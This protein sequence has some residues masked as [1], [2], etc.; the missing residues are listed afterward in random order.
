LSIFAATRPERLG[1]V[2]MDAD[3]HIRAA[4]TRSVYGGVPS[5]SLI[6]ILNS[7]LLTAVLERS[8]SDPRPWIWF[9]LIVGL[10]AVRLLIWRAFRRRP[11]DAPVGAWETAAVACSFLSGLLSGLGAAM[12]FPPDETGQWLWIF[13][14]GGMC[15]GAA[16]LDA[17]HSPTALAFLFPAGVPLALR[18]AAPGPVQ[19]PVAAAMIL[20]F[21]AA[22]SFTSLRFS[23]HF[24]DTQRLQ[25]DLERRTR[26]LDEANRRLRA[27]IEQHRATEDSLRQAQ[28]ME[29]LGLLTGGI[30]H[31][32]NNLLTVITGNLDLMRR[33]AADDEAISRLANA[34]LQAA[35]RGAQLTGSLLSF[36][37]KQSLRPAIIDLN[38]LISDFA[39]LLRRA[40][41][42]TV[43]LEF[44]LAA[45]PA[46]A[47]ADAAHFQSA[48]LNLVINARDAM[49]DGGRVVISTRNAAQGDAE[50]AAGGDL[51]PGPFVV[52]CVRDEGAGM[53]PEVAAKAFEPF[54][55]TKGVGKG[56]GLGLSQVY[57]FARQSG[58]F[59][60]LATGV[61]RG[62]AVS[63]VL[64]VEAG[65]QGEARP[66][67]RPVAASGPVRAALRVLLV[68]D[69]PLVLATLREQLTASGFAVATAQN[70]AQ[71]L[72]MLRGDA[73][74]G[75]LVSD[76]MM[77]GALGGVDLARA[78]RQARPELPVLLIS[79]YPG[80][81]LK[82]KG[83]ADGEFVLLQKPLG[84]GELT[85]RILA[86]TAQRAAPQN[87]V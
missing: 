65:A 18:L 38:A 29:A 17:A 81:A 8:A 85:E 14:I 27:E 32:F 75:V 22:V 43:A 11:S 53:S 66:P 12:L 76:V 23:R 41:G 71:G 33:R 44:E 72:E 79:G 70:G 13:V 60:S 82:E 45:D 5:A 49:P 46:T 7:A 77:P 74:V 4:R 86:L 2:F 67:A 19:R 47:N 24:V 87:A 51:G 34:A 26:E 52:A 78:A 40:T 3:T 58:G 57:G 80:D 9:G 20:V 39:P 63:I 59:A 25:L 1:G 61:G 69:D 64:P 15:A 62:A 68:E 50:L 37:R 6:S 21:V 35:R 30:A 16:S 36:A 10:A 54:F 31:D 48:L 42:E 84:Q 55:T 28:K 56:S 73:G 83:V